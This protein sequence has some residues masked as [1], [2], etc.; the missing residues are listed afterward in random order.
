[1]ISSGASEFL[2]ARKWRR[3]DLPADYTILRGRALRY[4]HEAM[5]HAHFDALADDECRV[6]TPSFDAA[7]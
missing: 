7:L 3:P 5:G 4:R 1:M 6:P 2:A